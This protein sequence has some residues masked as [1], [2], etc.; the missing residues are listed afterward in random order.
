MPFGSYGF[1]LLAGVLTALSPC[2]LPLLPIILGSALSAHRHGAAAL[3]LGLALSFAAVGLFVATI[4]FAAGFDHD[5]FRSVAA[6]ALIVLGLFMVVPALQNRFSGALVP[7]ASGGQLLMAR[8]SPAG[9]GGQFL[10]GLLFG[11]VWSPCVGP[12]LGA[13]AALAAQRQN[14]AQAAIVM[15]LF[16]IGAALPMLAIGRLGREAMLHW[17]GTLLGAGKIGKQALG[18][19]MIALAL[20]VLTGADK[21]IETYLVAISPDWLSD[22][23]TRF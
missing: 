1:G 12:T 23:T 15:V 9:F 21:V 7:V 10:L 8:I 16:A 22:I 4:G 20:L 5:V 17:R 13:T 11:V 19:V 14:L 3:V 2:V 18:G 6:V